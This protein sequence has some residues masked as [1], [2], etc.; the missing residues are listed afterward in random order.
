VKGPLNIA[1]LVVLTG[2]ER[3]SANNNRR[4]TAVYSWN[5]QRV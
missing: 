2:A 1:K 3:K 5:E 4:L